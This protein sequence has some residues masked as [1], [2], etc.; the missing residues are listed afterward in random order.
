L[1]R[2]GTL[3]CFSSL[4]LAIQFS[5]SKQTSN[6]TDRPKQ[7]YRTF[8]RFRCRPNCAASEKLST[9]SAFHWSTT[10]SKIFLFRRGKCL[11]SRHPNRSKGQSCANRARKT[12]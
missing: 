10:F 8:V 3:V 12:T 11:R 2:Q 9:S 1:I 7:P 5:R 4:L 6:A